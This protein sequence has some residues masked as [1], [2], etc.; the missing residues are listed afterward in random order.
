MALCVCMF[1][2][3][4]PTRANARRRACACICFCSHILS[5]QV[6]QR[7][8]WGRRN[9]YS[10][11]RPSDSHSTQ[12]QSQ[13][14]IATSDQLSQGQNDKAFI[15]EGIAAGRKTFLRTGL[16]ARFADGRLTRPFCSA[17]AVNAVR[18]GFQHILIDCHS[19]PLHRGWQNLRTRDGRGSR[20]ETG[21]C[22]VA[23]T[24]DVCFISHHGG[25]MVCRCALRIVF[26]LTI[27]GEKV[28]AT[29][30]DANVDAAQRVP[31]AD[32][33]RGRED[34]LEGRTRGV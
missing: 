20:S 7:H 9:G 22:R 6:I 18:N 30:F 10:H 1:T 4:M 14:T 8:A 34:E 12:L 24:W 19:P 5:S 23:T 21:A 31:Y 33:S 29:H 11:S 32:R 17:C 28:R 26:S 2:T 15:L 27:W 16:G 13:A 25:R 3:A